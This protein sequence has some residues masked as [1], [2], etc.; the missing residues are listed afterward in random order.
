[1][2]HRERKAHKVH[3]EPIGRRKI[4]PKISVITPTNSL[5]WFKK[6]RGSMLYQSFSDWEWIVLFNGGVYAEDADS[7]IKCVRSQIGSQNVGALKREACM[8]CS[9]PYIVEFDHDDELDRDCLKL[10]A[11][12]FENTSADF[13]YSE[14]ACVHEDGR[15]K[16]YNRS[17]GWDY[18]PAHFN[19]RKKEKL[20]SHRLP[21]LLPQN[22]SRIWFAPDHVRAWKTE[23]YW[24]AGGHDP[25]LKICDDQDLMC[26]MLAARMKFFHIPRCLYKYNIHGENTWLTNNAEIQSLT[27]QLHDKY[28]EAMALAFWKPLKRC[29][30]LGGGANSPAGWESCD[31]HDAMV[32]SDLNETWPFEDGSVGVF[33]AHDLIGYLKNPIHLM[34]EAW[35]CL[36]HGGLL[37]IEVPSTDGRG[38]FQDP[39]SASFWNENS[40]WYYTQA[41]RVSSSELK[42]AFQ[43]IRVI[44]FFP[45][46][47]HRTNNIPYV[48]AHL[49]AIKGGPR[50]HGTIE[51]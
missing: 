44:T 19:G 49:A 25:S 32:T 42:A 17:Y 47:W 21:L 11:E 15:P 16:L 12:A 40:F 13:V 51:I 34:N 35:R 14:D 22:V 37:L 43:S 41:K 30:D 20:I 5:D 6:A 1:M 26:R 33:R 23:S 50:L 9:A 7:R 46:E 2:A 45:S 38:A 10:V 24:K 29:I 3:Q 28:I 18:R 8:S 39:A 36:T 48:R 27:I 4:M 31:L